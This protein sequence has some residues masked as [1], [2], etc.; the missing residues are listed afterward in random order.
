M[1]K[2]RTPEDI[3]QNVI[4][5]RISK[6]EA[7]KILDSL[8]NESYRSE[9]RASV[10]DV[11]E[12]LSLFND[13]VYGLLEKA[14]LSDESDIVRFEAAKV[15][16]THF[17]LSEESSLIYALENEQ[18]IYV[19]RNVL[20][21]NIFSNESSSNKIKVMILNRISEF[22][23]LNPEDAQFI[24]D[25]DYL[26]Y[27]EFKE[28]YYSFS[29]KF[30]IP[31]NEMQEILR[32][33]AKLGFKGLG[34]IIRSN[35]GFIIGL[36]LHDL[37]EIPTSIQYLK[38]LEYLEIKRSNLSN[39]DKN[40]DN[41]LN[42]KALVLS[43]NRMDVLPEWIHEVARRRDYALK[44]IK[45][46][47]EYK[48]AQ[49]LGLLEI[50]LGQALV[51]LDPYESFDHSLLYYFKINHLGYVT[52]INISSNLNKIGIFP[53]EICSLTY[54][55]ELF[56]PNQNLRK[57][58]S[59]ISK[60]QNLENLDLRDNELNTLPSSINELKNLKNLKLEGNEINTN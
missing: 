2:I 12:K 3:Y 5:K 58:P 22:Y 56:M 47:V 28:Y 24:M 46:D 18:S 31:D 35:Q 40:F 44:Y 51:K 33:K 36:R 20:Q 59:C 13:E 21:L 14:L 17:D 50:L 42:L 7:L 30:N 1:T 27:I 23:N 16:I 6:K 32:E 60:L 25:I 19:L 49:V 15:I 52:G 29:D 57:I 8:L 34:R 43:N 45:Y 41:L 26:D 10:I 38:K 4:N 9:I 54:L 11:I 37:N 55:Q 39:L 53:E 48:E